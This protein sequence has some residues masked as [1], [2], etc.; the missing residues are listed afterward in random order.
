MEKKRAWSARARWNLGS[1]FPFTQ[2]LGIYEDLSLTQGG[3]YIDPLTSGKLAVWYAEINEGR[4]PWYH[5]L[6]ISLTGSWKLSR[7]MAIETVFSVMNVYNRRN[8][9]YLDRVTYNRVD[10]LPI[11]PTFGLRLKL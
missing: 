7:T 3:L 6:D 5:R 11:L 1:G 10:Q 8:V 9:F 2:S 4:M